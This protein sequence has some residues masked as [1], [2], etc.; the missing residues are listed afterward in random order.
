EIP[1]EAVRPGHGNQKWSICQA[2]TYARRWGWTTAMTA[3]EN[4][5]VPA[6]AMNKWVDVSD[7]DL[8]ESQ[9]R[10]GWHLDRASEKARFEFARKAFAGGQ[11][12]KAAQYNGL[13]SSPLHHTPVEPDTVLVFGDGAHVTH[14]VHA[15]CY[16]YKAPVMSA[17]EGFGESCMK[18]GLLPFITGRPQV[19][20]PGMGDRAFA[21]I[22]DSE[23]GIGLPGNML[24][25]VMAQLF[26]SGGR[27]N[28]GQ[29]VKTL[30]PMGL[31][32]AITP[33]FQFLKEK[34]GSGNT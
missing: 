15:L 21:G 6:S 4:F 31:T 2:F 13:V 18:G 27:Q 29:P 25:L 7:E 22:G 30:L 19:V 32:E 26:K 28:I 14:I 33:G 1:A 23:I 10:Q 8:V 5:C 17:F 20:I 12:E 34:I 24:P 9:V 3:D 16:D 11:A